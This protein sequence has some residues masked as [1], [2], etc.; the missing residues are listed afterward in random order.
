MTTVEANHRYSSAWN[1]I[2]LRVGQRHA[3][4]ANYTVVALAILGAPFLNSAPD[5]AFRALY[6]IPILGFIF[7]KLLRMHERQIAI[8]RGFLVKLEAIDGTPDAM[9]RFFHQ[10]CKRGKLAHNARR[11]HDYICLLMIAVFTGT[12]TICWLYPLTKYATL[13]T[14]LDTTLAIA[15]LI[16][17]AIT[18]WLALGIESLRNR[19]FEESQSC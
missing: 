19:I 2:N 9:P 7:I 8:L 18:A 3:L 10:D 13:K 4:T 5:Y 11:I 6:V 1:E 15:S 14:P 12:A 17:F 16:L